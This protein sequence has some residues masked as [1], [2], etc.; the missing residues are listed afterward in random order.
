[1]PV[2]LP[3]RCCTQD[4]VLADIDGDR[5]TFPSRA[6]S[7]SRALG[8]AGLALA[9]AACGGSGVRPAAA[10]GSPS[11]SSSP[12]PS[13]SHAAAAPAVYPLTGLPVRNTAAAH[14]PAL[15]VKIDNIAPAMPQAGLNRADLVTDILV[16]GGLTR[17]MATFQS[18]DVTLIGPI[19]SA[20][21]VDADLLRQLNGGIFAYSGAAPGEIAPSKAHS[22]ALLIAND[23]AP[24]WFWRS[25]SR[26]AP[27]NVFS[28]T[29]RLY[30]AGRASG[31]KLVAPPQL[32]TYGPTPAGARAAKGVTLRFSPNTSSAW[33]WNGTSYVRTQDGRPD[34]VADGSRVST[35]NV[36]VLSVT[37]HSTN[38]IDDA[39]NADPYVVVIGSGPATVFRNGVA[40]AGHWVRPSYR[41]PMKIL[42][43]AG[44]PIP[45]QPG[46]TWLELQPR[47]Y[48]PA[49]F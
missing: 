10:H 21:P 12:S 39:G 3:S 19:R 41:V 45:L 9:L 2:I 47:P 43:A 38:I 48:S 4:V 24:Q 15:S 1:L 31:R 25:S 7:A 16:E 35:T 28:S 37:W 22:N 17:L 30:Q 49:L 6:T 29:S 8:A 36:V 34:M 32:F 11:P 20:R 13:A 26:A 5:V 23:N 46:R 40:I 42:D 14:R 44:H 27:H 18:Q 33:T